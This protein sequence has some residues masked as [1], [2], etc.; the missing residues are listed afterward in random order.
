M[1]LEAFSKMNMLMGTLTKQSAAHRRLF[2]RPTQLYFKAC[3]KALLKCA[4]TKQSLIT[5]FHYSTGQGYAR[6]GLDYSL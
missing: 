6:I 3:M 1:L 2:D 4:A 5:Y